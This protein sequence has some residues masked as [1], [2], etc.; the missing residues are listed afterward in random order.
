MKTN[1]F[2]Y[3]NNSW[4]SKSV[5]KENE[6][7]QIQLV[8]CF[9]C[10]EIA[11][12]PEIYQETK[13]M[14]PNAEIALSSTAGE[15]YQEEV[16]DNSL[17]AVAINFD[18]TEIKTASV[19]I[20]DF[21]TS[22]DAGA[23]LIKKLPPDDLAYILILS[24]GNLVN[25]SQLVKGFNAVTEKKILITGGLAGDGDRF[26]ST[27]LGLNE[28]PT[29]GN[30][31]AI[32]FYGKNIIIGHGSEGGWQMFGP[33]REVTRSFNNNLF[34]IDNTSA[35]DLYRKYLGPFEDNVPISTLLFPLG[36]TLPGYS[37]PLVRTILSLNKENSSMIFAGDVPQGSQVRF[38]KASTNNLIYAAE[39]AA[40]KAYQ[41]AKL[42]PDL[43]LLIS[44]IGRKLIMGPR[45][46]EEIEAVTSFNEYKSNTIGFYAYGEISP[47]NDEIECQLNN[48]TM[49]VTAFYEL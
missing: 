19:N 27:V 13:T 2:K 40:K 12:L 36:V 41:I 37:K 16:Y 35:F 3:Q 26:Q 21:E 32:A 39:I 48:E 4:T 9:A 6:Y 22:F 7:Q 15:I 25:G 43:T 14:F 1:L 10:K 18:K 11:V 30:V 5:L 29:E 28:P 45:V 49:T 17:V 44:C 42:Q 8:L 23:G 34:E 38:M 33:D 46:D 24:D 31:I 20:R 47:F